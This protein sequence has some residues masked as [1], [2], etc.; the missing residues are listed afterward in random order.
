MPSVTALPSKSTGSW[1]IP[2][3]VYL[4]SAHNVICIFY[5]KPRGKSLASVTASASPP[6]P[7]KTELL[8]LGA[9]TDTTALITNSHL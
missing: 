5:Y 3:L 4:K 7:A 9:T 1:T 8:L 2:G 6:K